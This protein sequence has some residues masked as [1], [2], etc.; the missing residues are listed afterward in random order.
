MLSS[1]RIVNDEAKR[2]ITPVTHDYSQMLTRD[3]Q[4]L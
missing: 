4:Q 3:E 2:G 1:L